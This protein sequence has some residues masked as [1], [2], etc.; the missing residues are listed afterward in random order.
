MS[1][2]KGNL[3]NRVRLEDIRKEVKLSKT[4]FRTIVARFK[5]AAHFQKK[6]EEE[7]V[8][9]EFLDLL[10]RVIEN[11]RFERSEEG[12]V[13]GDRR[14]ISIVQLSRDLAGRFYNLG[15]RA[16]EDEAGRKYSALH[17]WI[18]N[19]KLPF[20][21]FQQ[22]PGECK[23]FLEED[24]CEAFLDFYSFK[25]ATEMS[26]TTRRSLVNWIESDSLSTVRT[27]GGE[28]GV[29]RSEL[30]NLLRQKYFDRLSDRPEVPVC[31]LPEGFPKIFGLTLSQFVAEVESYGLFSPH[32]L[33]SLF[34]WNGF[35]PRKDILTLNSM[36]KVANAPEGSFSVYDP[37]K[38]YP[39]FR[40]LSFTGSDFES[41]SLGIV[42]EVFEDNPRK[43]LVRRK[44]LGQVSMSQ[45]GERLYPF[46]KVY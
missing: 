1:L 39:L 13:V 8:P 3:P 20:R 2:E 38:N 22:S 30:V 34:D 44:D 4:S 40:R 33:D 37:S 26:G 35:L 32:Q 19:K 17:S 29:S 14:F 25:R 10:Y 46:I 28:R 24:L 41:S 12:I 11:Y 31:V 5:K 18:R 42:S 27:S 23:Y 45:N 16:F 6:D 43:I 21:Q 9:A 36:I 7:Y 15:T